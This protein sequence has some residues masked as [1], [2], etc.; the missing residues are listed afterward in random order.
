V[1]LVFAIKSLSVPGGGAERVFT[2]IVNGLH[3]RGHEVDILTFET[4]GSASFYPLDPAIPRVDVGQSG[5]KLGQLSALP[6]ARQ[7]VMGARPEAVVA[8]MPSCYVPLGAALIGTGV[9]VIASEHNVPERYRKQPLRWLSIQAA[10]RYAA[11][12][13]AVSE[14]MRALYPKVVRDKM[15]VSPNPVAVAAGGRADAVG[16]PGTGTIL[17]VGRLHPQKDHVTLVRAFGQIAEQFPGWT[18]RIL[19][20]G[21]ERERIEGEVSRLGLADRIALPGT[22]RDIGREYR[23]AQLYAISSRFESYG[24]ATVEALAHGLPAVGF[25]DCPGTN[26]LIRDGVNG[27]LVQPG[28]DRVATLAETLAGLMAD[29]ERRRVLAEGAT[30]AEVHSLDEVLDLWETMLGEIVPQPRPSTGSR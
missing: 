27:V 13:T 12:F 9:P 15:V 4:G 14:Q 30:P 24:L 6:R 7:A 18:L 19:G 10:S 20:D 1:R 28:A 23:V 16:A 22:V 26:E 21:D 29:G 11:R 3:G 25:A 5:G 2:E 17:A 8:F